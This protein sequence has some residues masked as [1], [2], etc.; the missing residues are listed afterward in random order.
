MTN[1][2]AMSSIVFHP[3]FA[4]DEA[5]GVGGRIYVMMTEPPVSG[6]ADLG[7]SAGEVQQSVL[8][9]LR[10]S[11]TE[12]DS[13]DP[14]ARRELLRINE[15]STIHNLD[16][17]AFRP[18]GTLVVTK[19]DDQTGG[20]DTLTIHGTVLRIVVD[21]R[22]GNALSAN[23]QYWISA[24]NPFGCLDVV[25]ADATGTLT[26]SLDLTARPNEGIAAGNTPHFQAWYRD[27]AAGGA[28][29]NLSDALVVTFCP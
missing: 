3:D 9:E 10:P 25:Q 15:N 14:A 11:A 12:P 19:G 16:D 2:S 20:Q 6:T 13:E 1:G 29:F 27:P 18:D 21:G 23:G 22:P 17:L 7:G 24:D 5:A 8:Y 28:A 26:T 4:A